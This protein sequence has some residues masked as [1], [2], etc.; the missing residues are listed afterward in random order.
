[1]KYQKN[2]QKIMQEL[3]QYKSEVDEMATAYIAEKTKH[4]KQLQSMEGKYTESY[5]TE[6]RRNWKPKVNYRGVIDLARETHRKIAMSYFDKIKSE[7]DGYFQIPVDS[8]FASTVSAIKAVGVTLNNREFELLQGA[9]GGYW[10]R[11]LLNELA[12]SRTKTEQGTELEN[13]E[14]K[15]TEKETKIPYGGVEL[16]DIEKVYDSLQNILNAVNTAFEGYTGEE[17]QLKDIVFPKDRLAEVTHDKIASEYGVEPPKQTMN[18]MQ[19]S[20]MATSVKCFDENYH[21][22]VAFAEMMNVLE[23]TM[24]KPKKKEVLTDDDRRLIDSMIDSRYEYAA[25]EQAA[26]I[27]RADSRLAEILSLDERYKTAV[28]AALGEVS[29]NE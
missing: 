24:P 21:S 26:K 15:R 29:D 28:A 20:K 19:I 4:E 1:M 22:Y 3:S 23:S 11:R 2:L 7:M 18:A 25:K 13:G 9:S 14:M 16:P 6:E 10:G 5:I 27:A 17:Y 8:G 12:V